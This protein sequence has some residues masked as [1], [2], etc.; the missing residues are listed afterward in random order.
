M[1]Q[2][3]E[4]HDFI[5]VRDLVKVYAS[6]AGDF[7]ALQG[8]DVQVNRGEFVAVIGKSGCGK[9]TFINMLTGIDRPTS[10]E[11]WIAGVPVHTLDED[12]MAAWR[13]RNVGIV[14][15]SFQLLPTLTLLENILLPME[16][17]DVY[18]RRERR[19]RAM[20][21]L[22]TVGL[23]EH[24]L[25]LPAAISGG[26]QQRVAIARALAN[27][28]PL[29]VADEPTGNLDSKTSEQVFELF[30][31]LVAG[32]KT[33]LMV[34]HDDDQAKRVQRTIILSDG[35]IV[36]EYLAR[37]LAA[38]GRDQLD[39]VARLV[40]PLTYPP[41][42]HIIRQGEVGD[43]FYIIL[44]GQAEVYVEQPGGAQ[45]LV[46]RLEEGEYFGE[47]ALVGNGLRMAT[48]RAA[49]DSEIQ[50][51]ALDADAFN[52]LLE[53][54][55]ALRK[56]LSHVVDQRLIK[57]Y[58][59]ALSALELETLHEL[60]Q[61]LESESYAPG[62]AIIRQGALGET[63]YLILD[64]EVEVVVERPDGREIV[65]N[66]LKGGQYFG[67]MALLEHARRNAT[68]RSSGSA[69][70]RVVGLEREVLERLMSDSDVFRDEFT[71]LKPGRQTTQVAQ[72]VIAIGHSSEEAN[73]A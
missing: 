28:P 53:Q 40:T 5:R 26:Q 71:Q 27:D 72:P 58:V 18:S 21:L 35:Q 70:A 10:G 7:M 1:S 41:G 56:E 67:E 2:Q 14:F 36:N 8:L 64:G 29:I 63:F 65:I 32:G 13:G 61:G 57:S 20:Q 66:R 6:P 30:E 19:E 15:Q 60:T 24:A 69:P 4:N 73:D 48:V 34:T 52:Q 38:L 59:Q 43:K 16:L 9:S 55:P 50:V 17:N 44:Q 11:V 22:E 12:E 23:A 31:K 54:A 47:V 25:K 51:A 33:I 68:V 62:K 45:I 42:V 46:K 37:A 39:T 3:N 49:D